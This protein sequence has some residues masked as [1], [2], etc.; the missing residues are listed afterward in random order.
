MDPVNSN[1][2]LMPNRLS[3]ALITVRS[4]T[5][6]VIKA[7]A[8]ITAPGS[9]YPIVASLVVARPKRPLFIRVPWASMRA[10]STATT[11][12][13]AANPNV[14][15]TYPR[16]TV[17]R[18][19]AVATLDKSP[20]VHETNRAAGRGTLHRR[21]PCTSRRPPLCATRRVRSALSGVSGGRAGNN[22]SARATAVRGSRLPRQRR[23]TGPTT[24]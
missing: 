3:E 15:R 11:A 4:M 10:M 1:P 13:V 6:T 7:P 5:A 8:A 2:G 9:A 24:R 23:E 19:F 21:S 14:R 22:G 20:T 12:A 17:L 16:Y 18:T